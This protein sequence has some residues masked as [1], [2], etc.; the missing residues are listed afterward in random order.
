LTTVPTFDAYLQLRPRFAV[1]RQLAAET[2]ARAEPLARQ[3][4][5][6]HAHRDQLGLG[7]PLPVI[8]VITSPDDNGGWGELMPVW[9]KP[10]ERP[11]PIFI[12]DNWAMPALL[13]RSWLGD[14]IGPAYHLENL[15]R[16]FVGSSLLIPFL[17]ATQRG[18]QFLRHGAL[19]VLLGLLWLPAPDREAFLAASAAGGRRFA[20]AQ[21]LA[22]QA[23]L[24]ETIGQVELTAFLIAEGNR[25]GG[26]DRIKAFLANGEA[27]GAYAD[28]FG[29]LCL[30]IAAL[31]AWYGPDWETWVF[32]AINVHYRY[33]DFG[34]EAWA[35]WL[36]L[37][38]T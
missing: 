27:C 21:R 38:N 17:P 3:A 10:Y 24:A 30:G 6:R 4:L 37:N 22:P 20:Q 2:L 23:D 11:L 26:E 14:A 25:I 12:L 15:L 18:G 28:L 1:S 16:I 19:T 34:L 8:P 13:W 7:D 35:Q 36:G 32:Q 9:F 33:A 5:G 31:Y 29:G